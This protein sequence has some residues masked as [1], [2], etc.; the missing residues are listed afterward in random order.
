MKSSITRS[1]LITGL[2]AAATPLVVSAEPAMGISNAEPPVAYRDSAITSSIK[3]RLAGDQMGGFKHIRVDTDDHGIVTLKGYARTQ[4]AADRAIQ[5]TKE[6]DG[7]REVKSA[8]E[9]K[10][11]D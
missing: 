5:I 6:T 11:D 3:A 1:W 2:L 4:E 7:V 10:I 8:I 9:I